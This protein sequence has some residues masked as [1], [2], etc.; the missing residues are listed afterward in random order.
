MDFDDD[1]I[2]DQT[3]PKQRQRQKTKNLPQSYAFQVTVAFILT[4]A[5]TAVLMAGVAFIVWNAGQGRF[6]GEGDLYAGLLITAF[7]SVL[8]AVGVGA[9]FANGIVAPVQRI[10]NT[11]QAVKEGDLSA[12]T[13]LHSEDE[14]GRLGQAFDEMA[15]VMERDRE[16]ERQ[17]IGDVAHEL[18]T[19]L[20]AVQATVE[21]IQ[22]GVFEADETRLSTISNETRRLSRLVDA[23]LHLNRLE[24]GT[25]VAKI[26]P[27]D[28]SS[29]LA[30][31]ALNH[32]ALIESAEL[33]FEAQIDPEVRIRGDKDLISQAVANLLSNAVRY[34]PEGGKITL[35]VT[36]NHGEA[37]ISVRDTGIGISPEDQRKVFSRFWRADAARERASG[38]LGIGLAMV[39]EV[40]D[41]HH[42]RVVLESEL[43]VGSTFSIRIPLA[44]DDPVV[45]ASMDKNDLRRLERAARK[46][47]ERQR[48]EAERQRR[49]AEKGATSQ[50]KL[51]LP[52]LPGAKKAPAKDNKKKNHKVK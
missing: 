32:Q 6:F 3:P 52:K 18:R 45:L 48:K 38:G 7:I 25:I 37:C 27:L 49:A 22:D 31:L 8:L 15:E 29:S 1:Q 17:L 39:K 42:G 33:H 21:A 4:A 2:E 24:N 41:Q 28:L 9:Y 47:A 50:F 11:V 13:G 16:L 44:A 23:L 10:S 14:I 51:E 30:D 46:E 19:P 36:R 26:A 40:A 20:M 12:R 43:G 34:T 5:A 35:I